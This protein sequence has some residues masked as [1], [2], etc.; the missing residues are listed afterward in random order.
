MEGSAAVW[1]VAVVCRAVAVSCSAESV[2]EKG[3]RSHTGLRGLGFR[4]R[5]SETCWVLGLR[6]PPISL[7]R[8]P[9]AHVAGFS[10]AS[11]GGFL[12]CRSE[13]WAGRP[14]LSPPAPSVPAYQS[15]A[16]FPATGNLPEFRRQTVSDS[17]F[18]G[19]PGGGL[20]LDVLISGEPFVP[21]VALPLYQ[22]Y[23]RPDALNY[24]LF[25][26]SVAELGRDLGILMVS[27][28]APCALSSSSFASASFFSTSMS[29][30]GF[31]FSVSPMWYGLS[32]TSPGVSPET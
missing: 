5:S 31:P 27:S 12:L 3:S 24:K 13:G 1:R 29:M 8:S 18:R 16:T 19:Q 14:C 28:E 26:H 9:V 30:P 25:P 15:P 17:L 22:Y 23:S 4:K 11:G 6:E 7:H 21:W 20:G 32:F 2:R 10:S